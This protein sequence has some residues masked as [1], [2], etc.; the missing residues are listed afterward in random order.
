M[1]RDD[2]F[3]TPAEMLVRLLF[4]LCLVTFTAGILLVVAGVYSHQRGLAAWGL[5]SLAVSGLLREGLS[6]NGH[7]DSAKKSL[8]A[9]AVVEPPADQAHLARLAVLLRE[10]EALERRRGSA[11][12]DPWQL[13]ALRNDIRQIVENDPALERLF[14]HDR[15]AA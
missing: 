9:I 8:D 1:K 11:D 10:W 3:N 13:Q 14:Q 4:L 12:F 6:R 5:A 2:E 15:R 7:F